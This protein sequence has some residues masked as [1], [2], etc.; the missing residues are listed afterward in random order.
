MYFAGIQICQQAFAAMI[1]TSTA[2]L[3]RRV[4]TLLDLRKCI[5]GDVDILISFVCYVWL[6]MNHAS[7]II[8][9]SEAA[10]VTAASHCPQSA[11]VHEFLCNLYN[12][13]A[14]CLPEDVDAVLSGA[15][16]YGD[17]RDED[18]SHRFTQAE[19]LTFL[20]NPLQ[21]RNAV[22]ASTSQLSRRWLTN[23]NIMALYWLL[24]ATVQSVGEEV[25]PPGVTTFR[26]VFFSG[27]HK[28]LGFRRYRQHAECTVC[29]HLRRALKKFH[30]NA[31]EKVKIAH[32][33][34]QHWADQYRD[35]VC[36]W[37]LRASSRLRTV[38]ILAV[39]IDSLDKGKTVNP[40]FGTHALNK[41]IE[42][43]PSRPSSVITLA[44]AHGFG[45]Y[46][47]IT[48][49]GGDHG[50]TLFLNILFRVLDFVSR[51]CSRNSWRFPEHLHV[52]ARTLTAKTSF[53]CSIFVFCCR[54]W[55]A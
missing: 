29:W 47:F 55:F 33:L 8:G 24:I 44:K 16:D 21:W 50:S 45:N 2:R 35:R 48:D 6:G 17:V 18:T 7:T 54:L 14:E 20:S 34:R 9:D 10:A 26:R 25:R 46:I 32:G 39:I 40:R 30:A 15:K 36:Y 12:S 49:E 38:G 22:A 52:Q 53:L 4:N 1:G 28:V 11:V 5:P 27:W 51:L 41:E 19:N 23:T 3:K 31:A 37:A 13:S 43:L 42:K